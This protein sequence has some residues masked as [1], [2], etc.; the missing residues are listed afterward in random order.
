LVLL[1]VHGSL[2]K[3]FSLEHLFSISRPTCFLPKVKRTELEGPSRYMQDPRGFCAKEE[4]IASG[5]GVSNSSNR[6]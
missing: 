2:R 1:V 5:W 6:P 4:G 3:K